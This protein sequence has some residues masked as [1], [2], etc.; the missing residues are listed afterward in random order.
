MGNTASDRRKEIIILKQRL[1]NARIN[2]E[3]NTKYFVGRIQDKEFELEHTR[4]ALRNTYSSEQYDLLQ[5]KVYN[6]RNQL[7]ILNEGVSQ[8]SQEATEAINILQSNLRSAQSQNRVLSKNLENSS[9]KQQQT[10]RAVDQANETISV[11]EQQLTA[12]RGPLNTKVENQKTQIRN[13]LAARKKDQERVKMV[14]FDKINVYMNFD[15]FL[16]FSKVL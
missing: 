13:L 7:R 5:T 15:I 14:I 2:A 9:K 16:I 6:Q 8:K 11:L 3:N 1:A 10:G 12:V 4:E